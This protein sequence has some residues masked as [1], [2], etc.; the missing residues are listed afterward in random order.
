MVNLFLNKDKTRKSPMTVYAFLVGLVYCVIFGVA[1]AV[2]TDPLYRLMPLNNTVISA[3][4]QSIVI[5]LVG[6]AVC[7][8]FFFLP[9]KR[10]ALGGFITLAILLAAAFLM[11]L[12]LSAPQRSVLWP[13]LALYGLGPVLVGNIAGF[14]LYQVLQ[15]RK[16]A[17]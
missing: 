6:A 9:D 3:T 4:L 7:C 11:T 17:R 14:V 12:L 2:L 10:V 8:L 5:S 15:K 13:M 1:F 16:R